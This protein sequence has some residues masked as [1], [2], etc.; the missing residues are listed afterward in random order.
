M[1]LSVVLFARLAVEAD[2]KRK[3]DAN[4]RKNP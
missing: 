4:E 1:L 3:D 2:E